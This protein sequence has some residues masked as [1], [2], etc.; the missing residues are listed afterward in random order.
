MKVIRVLLLTCCFFSIASAQRAGLLDLT[1]TSWRVPKN[2][3]STQDH[4]CDETRMTI[5]EGEVVSTDRSEPKEDLRLSV[6]Q[7]E[8]HRLPTGLEFIVTIRLINYGK[9]TVNVPWETDGEKVVLLSQNQDEE[10]YDVADLR[11]TLVT[12]G[13]DRMSMKPGGV[14]FADVGLNRG[15]IELAPSKWI[16][17]RIRGMVECDTSAVCGA[18]RS[19]NNGKLVATWH[20]RVRTHSLK[21]CEEKSGNFERR[22]LSS[23]PYDLS[24][25]P[26]NAQIRREF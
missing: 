15:S 12:A 26:A 8:P 17:V 11:L 2:H 5:G 22:E 25:K 13:V 24:V 23:E 1:T 3:L 9:S 21:G 6:A 7:V 14:L 19:D 16:E 20:E 4:K 18:L 10:S